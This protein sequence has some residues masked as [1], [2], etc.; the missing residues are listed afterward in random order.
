MLGCDLTAGGTLC[1]GLPVRGSSD[2][3]VGPDLLGCVLAVMLSTP[4]LS[5]MTLST[6]T[7]SI[8]TL[9]IVTLSIVT[10]SIVTL[11]TAALWT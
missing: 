11:S 1:V 5:T 9:S 6:P 3:G 4:V 10:P 7:L 2:V 8:V